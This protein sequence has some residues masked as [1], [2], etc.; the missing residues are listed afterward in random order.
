M[1]VQLPFYPCQ[2]VTP[3]RVP[4]RELHPPDAQ[5]VNRL[6]EIAKGGEYYEALYTAFYTGLRR[7]E[8]LALRWRDVGLDLGT[9]AVTRN[10]YVKK[11]GE[12]AYDDPKTA[13]GRRLVSL[14]PSTVTMLRNL[15]KRQL[16]DAP[17]FG[18]HIDEESLLFRYRD[19]SP[20]LPR[21]LTGAFRKIVHQ[22]GMK[23]YRLH[24][25]RHAH[26]TLMLKQSV[27]PKIVQER[28]G[29]AKVGTTLDIYSHVTPGLQQAAALRFD[30]GLN[31]TRQLEPITQV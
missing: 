5:E 31:A 23:D 14:T 10:V 30:E 26:A 21:G 22:A 1:Y 11:G 17:L 24:D 2:A 8:L 19:G 13:K 25:A 6:L 29:H 18:Y 4:R 12:P 16:G 3:P 20:I 9:I 15:L 27:H 28:F 7:G